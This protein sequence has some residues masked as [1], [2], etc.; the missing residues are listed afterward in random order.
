MFLKLENFMMAQTELQ[1]E[2]FGDKRRLERG[3]EKKI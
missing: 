3:Y 2:L 1:L